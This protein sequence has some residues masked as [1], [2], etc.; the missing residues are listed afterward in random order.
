[1]ALSTTSHA[2][3]VLYEQRSGSIEMHF[4]AHCHWYT[5]A[6]AFLKCTV[7]K[8]VLLERLIWR[9]LGTDRK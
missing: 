7:K 9:Q 4:P 6:T 3:L 8:V 1:M 2:L 5:P